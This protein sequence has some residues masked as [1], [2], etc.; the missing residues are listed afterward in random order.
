MGPGATHGTASAAVE[1]VL[2]AILTL[3]AE[4]RL[5]ITRFGSFE[6]KV[7]PARRAYSIAE[8]KSVQLSP[9]WRLTFTPAKGFPNRPI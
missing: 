9:R 8:G 1:A 5:H 6:Q 7:V 4:E 2:G 3:S